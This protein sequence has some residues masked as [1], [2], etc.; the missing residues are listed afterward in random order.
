MIEER[1]RRAREEAERRRATGHNQADSLD[2]L[3]WMLILNQAWDP[4]TYE[5]DRD[6][7]GEAEAAGF[8]FAD[9]TSN[10]G[11]MTEPDPTPAPDPEPPQDSGTSQ[12][13]SSSYG[14]SGTSSDHGSSYDSGSSSSYDSGSSSDS[15]GGFDSGGG[16]GFD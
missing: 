2:A 8:N 14:D 9:D 3:T 12:D 7:R 5:P 10:I 6:Y 1:K 11:T 13:Y 16:G 4:Q 15:G